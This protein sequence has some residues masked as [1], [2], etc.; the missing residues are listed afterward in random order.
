[1]CINNSII[2][3]QK[4]R[5][6]SNLHIG[7]KSKILG[8]FNVKGKIIIKN[9]V[10]LFGSIE[11]TNNIT[12]GKNVQIHG[13]IDSTGE[14]KIDDGTYIYG[15]ISGNKIFLSKLTTINGTI[16]ANNGVTFI[17]MIENKSEDKIRRFESNLDKIEGLEELLE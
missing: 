15:D 8:N 4:S 11:N 14:I 6:D 9:D 5:I 17:P 2:G 12:C 16:N 3:I 10:T 1:M 13:N 7:Q